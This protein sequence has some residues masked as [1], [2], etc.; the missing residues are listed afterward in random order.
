[1]LTTQ[2]V[3]IMVRRMEMQHGMLSMMS[4]VRD[5]L[6]TSAALAD[7]EHHEI[8]GGELV[9]KASPSYAHGSMQML[10]GAALRGFYGRGGGA[11]RPGGWWLGTEV[12]IELARYEVY[13]PDI[14]GWRIDRV[15]EPP[16]ERPVRVAPDWV[17]EVLSPS[18]ASRDLGHKLRTYQRAH[19]G[20]YWVVEPG[21]QTITVYRW[22]E[23]GYVVAMAAGAGEMVRAEPFEAMELDVADVFGLPPREQ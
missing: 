21:N 19:V 7:L 4:Q 6:L 2:Q 1:M 23:A 20:H 11:G 13:L 18:T 3:G 14:A 5:H 16:Q 8:V 9:R 17:C 12:E 10:L 22:H 15:S